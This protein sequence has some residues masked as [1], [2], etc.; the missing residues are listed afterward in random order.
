[1]LPTSEEVKLQRIIYRWLQAATRFQTLQADLTEAISKT[2]RM[3]ARPNADVADFSGQCSLAQL[4]A[5]QIELTCVLAGLL[6]DMDTAGGYETLSA[7][8]D[9]LVAW[10]QRIQRVLDCNLH[11]AS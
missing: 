6:R 7:H 5:L 9:I 3:A 2:K 4:E 1:M 11:S 10:N 8:V